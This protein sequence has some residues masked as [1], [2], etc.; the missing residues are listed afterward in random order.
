M[1]KKETWEDIQKTDQK[2]TELLI[3][4]KKTFGRTELI[5]YNKNVPFTNHSSPIYSIGHFF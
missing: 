1:N 5:S 3:E 2:L 4:L